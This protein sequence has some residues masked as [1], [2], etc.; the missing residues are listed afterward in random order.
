MLRPFPLLHYESR[1]QLLLIAVVFVSTCILP[2]VISLWYIWSSRSGDYLLEKKSNR[3][4]PYLSFSINAF[5]AYVFL[6]QQGV[7]SL[8]TQPLLA[9]SALVLVIVVI[10]LFWKISAH[11]AGIGGA[12]GL[13]FAYRG[14]FLENSLIMLG[15][16]VVLMGVVGFSRLYL[17]AHSLSQY[18]SGTLLGAAILGLICSWAL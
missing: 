15:F 9:A 10:N 12:I 11:G 17:G 4:L 8:V 6:K 13:L 2:S 3:T 16:L 1:H 5:V 7:H 14:L 18:L